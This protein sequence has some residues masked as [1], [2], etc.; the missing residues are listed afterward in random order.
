[1]TPAWHELV[2]TRRSVRFFTDEE[3]PRT[4]IVNLLDEARWAPSGG[5]AQPWRVV[6]VSP[7][8]ARSFIDVWQDEAWS[9]T[10]PT[11]SDELR[12]REPGLPIGESLDRAQSMA[13]LGAYVHGRP[14]LL[15]V[16]RLRERWAPWA[17]HAVQLWRQRRRLFDHLR[18]LPRAFQVA[19][20][21]SNAGLVTFMHT[22][23]LSASARGLGSCLQWHWRFAGTA[24]RE[25]GQLDR[26]AHIEGTVLVGRSDLDHP[27]LQSQQELA[28]RRAVEVRWG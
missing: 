1:M 22:L 10:V 2:R 16:Y 23:C 12:R 13:E 28:S 14:W 8:R 15:V 20:S 5:N 19:R 4:V 18:G 21:V 27:M 11:F 24:L 26:R 6:A 9:W 7:G 17:S 25:L 3:L